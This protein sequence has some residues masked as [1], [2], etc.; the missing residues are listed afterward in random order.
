M[1]VSV[2]YNPYS[3]FLSK[4]ERSTIIWEFWMTHSGKK[5][6]N[7]VCE[8][9]LQSWMYVG[10]W[11]SI[12]Y[13]TLFKVN[14]MNPGLQVVIYHVPHNAARKAYSL[15]SVLDFDIENPLVDFFYC[16]Q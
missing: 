6:Q 1:L 12:C 5:S 13:H 2:F 3:W 8:I 15:F 9:Y 14:L 4:Q 11:L 10:H 7:G 16:F